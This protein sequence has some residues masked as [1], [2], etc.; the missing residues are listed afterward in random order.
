[1]GGLVAAQPQ[2]GR[3]AG[4]PI[5]D[6]V[7]RSHAP[8]YGG[9]FA[10][11]RALGRAV[12]SL[13]V[14][15]DPQVIRRYLLLGRG[16]RCD[17]LAL[18]ESERLLRSL[19]FLA[20]AKIVAE[21]GPGDSLRVEVATVDEPAPLIS[22]GFRNQAPYLRSLALAN[23][24]VQG[25]AVAVGV[26]WSEGFA[27]RDALGAWYRNYDFLDRPWQMLLQGSLLARGY[28]V[29]SVVA[30]PLLSDLSRAGWLAAFSAT[31]EL[32]PFRHPG[33]LRRSLGVTRQHGEWGT[34]VR[35]GSPAGFA[36]AGAALS[37]E[38]SIPER[39]GVIVTDSGLVPDTSG[40]LRSR[41]LPFRSARLEVLAG[42]RNATF[43]RVAGFDA[44]AG[45]QDVRR[46]LQVGLALG[47]PMGSRGRKLY[48]AGDLYFGAGA[49]RSFAGLQV[50]AEGWQSEGSWENILASGRLAWYLR[51]HPR[52]TVVASA[53][54]GGGWRVRI[55][56]QLALGDARGGVRGYERAEIGGDR[57]AVLRVEERWR[58]G[59]VRGT[60]DAGVALF[61]DGG[62]LWPGESPLALGTP[63]RQAL[64][65]SLL[66]ALPPGS[67]RLWRADLAFPLAREAGARW[68]LRVGSQDRTRTFWSEPLDVQRSRG[69]AAPLSAYIA[70]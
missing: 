30:A 70:R 59:T 47:R 10:R 69:R 50:I 24:N 16:Q 4:Q 36:L 3:C 40:A 25:R 27:Y 64:G 43:L 63:L 49:Q 61:W 14:A 37:W 67:R 17:P 31:R 54:Y 13:H 22:L 45:V 62:R 21:D 41:Y 55:P 34:L 12:S 51:P 57:R 8:S 58:L 56:F 2:P 19:P 52:H 48:A 39:Q 66:A 29:R 68:T 33:E 1:M 35:L 11:S 5:G 7:I 9:L 46:G 20:D 6:V 60:A 28:D 42:Y 32:V 18:A 26:L 23:G 44:L 53:E 65:V 15:T 38:E